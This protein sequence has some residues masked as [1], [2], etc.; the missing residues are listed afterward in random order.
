MFKVLL[1][2][3]SGRFVVRVPSRRFEREVAMSTQIHFVGGEGHFTVEE[4]YEKVN[5]ELHASDVGRFTR[6]VGDNRSRVTVYKPAIAYIE[7]T[8]EVAP[9]VASA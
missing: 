4:D 1:S 5:A 2:A 7:E 6:V 8:T 9:R 3:G